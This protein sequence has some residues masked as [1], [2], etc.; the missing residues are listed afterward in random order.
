M[1][2]KDYISWEEYFMALAQLAAKRSKDPNSQVG[3]CIVS[4][5]H[6]IV[7]LGYNGWPIGINEDD[8]PWEREGD[9]LDTKYVYVV[10]SEANAILNAHGQQLKGCD[11]Y[12]TLFPCN[13]CTQLIIQAG[14]KKVI[15]AD[16]KYHDEDAFVASRKMLDLAGVKYELYKPTQRKV[17]LEV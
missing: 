4:P 13:E 8:L 9:P 1:K 3:A 6:H 16:D 7:S 14:I 11:I 12:T 15:Y 2:R 5:D 10:H 17:T